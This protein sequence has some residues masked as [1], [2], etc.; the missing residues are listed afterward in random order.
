L[1]HRSTHCHGGDEQGLTCSRQHH[2][3]AFPLVERLTKRLLQRS[4]LPGHGRL[5]QAQ[6]LCGSTDISILSDVGERNQLFRAH[7]QSSFKYRKN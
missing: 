5:T 3:P 2:T 7:V 6:V 4:K 1:L